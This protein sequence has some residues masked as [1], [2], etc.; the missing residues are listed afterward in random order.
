MESHKEHTASTPDSVE[1]DSAEKLRDEAMAKVEDILARENGFTLV[2]QKEGVPTEWMIRSVLENGVLGVVPASIEPA[3]IK[4]DVLQYENYDNFSKKVKEEWLKNSRDGKVALWMNILGRGDISY[5]NGKISSYFFKGTPNQIALVF[6]L[7]DCEEVLPLS[8][9]H[10][11]S[12]DGIDVKKRESIATMNGKEYKGAS[13]ITNSHRQKVLFE[14]GFKYID[15]ENRQLSELFKK[16]MSILDPGDKLSES[17]KMINSIERNKEL[18]IEG[19]I[20][21]DDYALVLSEFKKRESKW[22]MLYSYEHF[23]ENHFP[24]VVYF[25]LRALNIDHESMNYEELMDYLRAHKTEA[26]AT[27]IPEGEYD[28]VIQKCLEKKSIAGIFESGVTSDNGYALSRRVAPRKLKGFVA[29]RDNLERILLIQEQLQLENPNFSP[30]PIYD[31]GAN[32]IWPQEISHDEL[33]NFE[34]SGGKK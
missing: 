19:G 4:P 21:E 23:E 25:I 2:R 15:H 11:F 27:G 13:Q 22:L 18:L 6:D 30:I 33:V 31:E 7:S 10:H 32:L 17:K 5:E 1:I 8:V 34:N 28:M 24:D 14:N 12:K 3:G 9:E 20:S 29:H 26:V 16:I